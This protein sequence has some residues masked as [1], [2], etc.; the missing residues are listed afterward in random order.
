MTELRRTV[1]KL[2]DVVGGELLLRLAN[3]AVAVL[4]GR[5]Y[6]AAALGFYAAILAVATV[7]ER[8]ADNGLELTGIAEVSR[9]SGSLNAV[10]TALYLD[11][12]ALSG[13]AIA[14]LL[15]V[16]LVVRL[17]SA[18]RAVAVILIARTF[19]YSYCRLN[20]GLLKALNR[21]KYITR[22]Q[23]AHFALLS[24]SVLMIY[25][26]GLGMT[27]L[28]ACLLAAQVVE[29][30]AGQMVLRQLGL[31]AH[32]VS[33]RFCLQMLRRSIA[34]GATYTF[35]TLMLRCDVVVLSLVASAPE[36]GAFAAANTGLVLLYVI[37]WLFSGTLLSD[38]GRLSANRE[39]FESHFRRCLRLVLVSSV[40]VAV[41]ASV[42]ARPVFLLVFGNKFASAALP[43][44]LMM[45]ALPFIFLN[46]TF[47]SYTIARRANRF[48]VSIYGGV[49]VVSLVLNYIGARWYGATG[50][51]GSIVV[52]EAVITL[53]FVMFAVLSDWPVGCRSGTKSEADFG[54]LP[55]AQGGSWITI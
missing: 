49:V 18:Y 7:A 32:F 40:P 5:V 52:R 45:L 25:A 29:L 28:V 9:N 27:T 24:S 12:T 3:V 44:A 15:V 8:I 1:S 42:L 36:V 13:A 16:A 50:V 33:I 46:G 17:P 26:L 21:T 39:L 31:H 51:A 35:S 30:V 53:L 43:G 54:G 20:A 37:A 10:A 11:K 2:A 23:S 6:G 38:L 19:I 34:I 55:N 48:S 47:L 41:M 14:L 4:I 22:L